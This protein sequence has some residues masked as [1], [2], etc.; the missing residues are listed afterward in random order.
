MSTYKCPACGRSN[1]DIPVLTPSQAVNGGDLAS[2]TTTEV[3]CKD[4]GWFG[5]SEDVKLGH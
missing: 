3:R 4:C 2:G 5:T 1:L